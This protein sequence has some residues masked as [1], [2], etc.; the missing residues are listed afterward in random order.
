M[1]KGIFFDIDDTLYDS[2]KLATMARRN[3]IKAMIDAGLPEKDES[4]VFD[5]LEGIIE[6]FG[7]NYSRHYDELVKELG[8]NWDPKIIAAGVVAYEHTKMGYLKPFPRVVPTLLDLKK[9][10]KLGVI[11]NGLAIKQWEKLVGLGIHHLFDIV[12]TSE[13]QGFEKPDKEIFQHAIEKL[14]FKP[15]ECVM[16]GDRIDTDILGASKAEMRTIWV[17]DQRSAREVPKENVKPDF[18]IEDLSEL[19]EVLQKIRC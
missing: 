10:Y 7:P 8:V 11:S 1:V 13:E 4:K 12:V 14:G 18:V 17:K 6:R 16:V 15:K 5:T 19:I 3:S 2:T 9:R